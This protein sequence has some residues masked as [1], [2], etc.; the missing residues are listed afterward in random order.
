MNQSKVYNTGKCLR[1]EARTSGSLEDQKNF[2][3]LHEVNFSVRLEIGPFED[4]TSAPILSIIP[5]KVFIELLART[6]CMC[7]V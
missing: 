2:I 3:V 4:K 7:G 5:F 1:L 6:V